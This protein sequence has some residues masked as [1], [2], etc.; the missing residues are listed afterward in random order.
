M[1]K[2]TISMAM[3]NS[4]LYVYQRV[5]IYIILY[6]HISLSIYHYISLTITI[7]TYLS[8]LNNYH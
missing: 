3:F 2:L 7:I 8:I 5:Y 6:S 4:F 1:G